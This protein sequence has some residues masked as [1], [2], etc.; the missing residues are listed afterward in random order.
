MAEPEEQ[1]D[2]KPDETTENAPKAGASITWTAS[3]YI[4][5]ARGASW[6]VGLLALS[7]L[8]AVV[9]YLIGHDLFAT[10]T[11][12]VLGVI[13]AVAAQRKPKQATYELNSQGIVIGEKSYPYAAFH[14]FSIMRENH[15]N[16]L[17]LT[18]LKRF[19]PPVSAYFDAD[20]EEEI[21]S[22]IGEHL[23]FEQKT[24]D[25]IDALTRRLR[26]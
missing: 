26:F 5:H 24:P 19:M 11:I 23:P 14:S 1:F 18:P 9:I 13:V 22:I 12:L 8:L 2:Y 25:R 21:T 15:L 3:E 6:Y 20:D 4:D 7:V 17:V 10:I 16:S